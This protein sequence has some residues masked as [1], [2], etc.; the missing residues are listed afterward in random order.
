MAEIETPSWVQVGQPVAIY[1]WR[2]HT[3]TAAIA[4]VERMTATQI[5]VGRGRFRR[6]NLREVGA[7]Y[8]AELRPVAEPRVIEALARQEAN[9][10]RYL[11]EKATRPGAKDAT[12]ARA[13]LDAIEE[14]VAKTRR[15]LDQIEG[16]Q[17]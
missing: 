3:P 6:D 12:E 5:I 11:I 13:M 15:A 9:H 8:S 16:P 1:D 2:N 14:I 17:W 10:A 4:K 7:S